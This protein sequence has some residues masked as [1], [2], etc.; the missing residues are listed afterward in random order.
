[1]LKG[2]DSG[3]SSQGQEVIDGFDD[4]LDGPNQEAGRSVTPPPPLTP[5]PTEVDIGRVLCRS[6]LSRC[7]LARLGALIAFLENF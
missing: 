1:M 5:P 7:Y 4:D 6:S 2:L 3:R